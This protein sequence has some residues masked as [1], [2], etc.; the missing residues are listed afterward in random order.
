L[1]DPNVSQIS[2]AYGVSASDV[3]NIQQ[4]I[5]IFPRIFSNTEPELLNIHMN[6]E[7]QIEPKLMYGRSIED[8]HPLLPRDELAQN[9]LPCA[10]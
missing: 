6:S 1:P 5:S 7:C 9:L 3:N 4:L 10:T 2:L 8:S